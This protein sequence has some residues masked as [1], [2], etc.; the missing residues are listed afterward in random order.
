MIDST[1]PTGSGTAADPAPELPYDGA[2]PN[3]PPG[4]NLLVYSFA[5]LTAS[6]IGGLL[7]QDWI[8]AVAI[9]VLFAYWRILVP[10]EGPPVL[11]LAFTYQWVQ[12]TIGV[13][14]YGMTQRYS[15]TMSLSNYRPMVL[16]GL[17]AVCA[18]FGGIA[19]AT[20]F[21]RFVNPSMPRGKLRGMTD[22]QLAIGYLFTL[23]TSG[24]I[25]QW[26]RHYPG[27]NQGAT[28]LSYFRYAFLFLIF[29]R[30]SRPKMR[31]SLF[32]PLLVFEILLGF[33]NFF[34]DFREPVI[35]A[36]LALFEVF[37]SRQVRHWVMFAAGMFAALVLATTWTAIK[38]E[39]RSTYAQV[40]NRAERLSFINMLTRRLIAN[41]FDQVYVSLDATVDRLWTVY[42]PALAVE[43]VPSQIPHTGG[44]M[45][46]EGVRSTITPRLFFPNKPP[47]IH[48]SEKVREY[49]GLYVAGAEEGSSIAFGY[50]AELY[51]DFGLP[52]MF[53]PLVIA[54]FLFGFAFRKILRSMR[55]RDIAVSVSVVEIWMCIFMFEQSWAHMLGFSL[56]ILLYMTAA[57]IMLDRYLAFKRRTVAAIGRA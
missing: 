11:A 38:P 27:L 19:L 16:I 57:G 53:Y 32:L 37:D 52:G 46:W 12:V 43:R 33:T 29:R 15:P 56:S 35:F 50:A 9:L 41:G 4:M 5:A 42:Y 7:A 26:G 25:L 47:L 44:K 18:L 40:E 8:G 3:G 6:I 22:R 49:S 17:G 10:Q 45:M 39:Y 54:G 48:D 36:L 30:L 55:Y 31:W 2:V 23:V 51:V 13:F 34:A 1:L 14:Y 20:R 28:V 21:Q 24:I